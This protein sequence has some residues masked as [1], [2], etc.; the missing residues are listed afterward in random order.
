MPH[1]SRLA[2]LV[3]DCDTD[4]LDGLDGAAAFW[5]AALGDGRVRKPQGRYVGLDPRNG[6]HVAVQRV[7]HPSRVHLDIASDD[8]PAEVA[9]LERLGARKV[10]E[11]RTRVVMEA[12][13]G[14][15]F[16]VIRARGADFAAGRQRL[17]R[18]GG[19]ARAT[20]TRRNGR[21]CQPAAA[22]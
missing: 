12:P 13:T 4:G 11:V 8:V 3:I 22:A 9:R 1:H 10:A 19:A 7:D 2:G 14:H 6:L 5:G 20:E 15:R 21:P 18:R 16:C 17:G